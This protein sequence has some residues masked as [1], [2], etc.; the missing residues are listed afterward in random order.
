MILNRFCFVLFCLFKEV[1]FSLV[2]EP[3]SEKC[4]MN[5]VDFHWFSA[6]V[7]KGQNIVVSQVTE[8]QTL[9]NFPGH[10]GAARR[11]TLP[12]HQTFTGE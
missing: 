11:W 5:A 12:A 10:L 3:A 4:V 2:Y 1:K 6:E 7:K 9:I 8:H